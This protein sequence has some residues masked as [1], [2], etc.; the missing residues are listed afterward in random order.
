MLFTVPAAPS[1]TD[2]CYNHLEVM[3]SEPKIPMD[4]KRHDAN[5]V[6]VVPCFPD[7]CG[8]VYKGVLCT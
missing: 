2:M 4:V 6:N 7:L 1:K 8:F 5:V 3:D